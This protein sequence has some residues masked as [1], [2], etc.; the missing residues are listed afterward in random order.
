MPISAEKIP[1]ASLLSLEPAEFVD[2][3]YR[4]ILGREADSPHRENYRNLLRLGALGRWEL[5]ELLCQSPEGRGRGVEFAGLPRRRWSRWCARLPLVRGVIR[6]VRLL[7]HLPG[8]LAEL[9]E[10]QTGGEVE[11]AAQGRRVEA[12]LHQADELQGQ[13]E[14]RQGQIAARQGQAEARLERAEELA[15][16]RQEL[17]EERYRLAGEAGHLVACRLAALETGVDSIRL[18]TRR[19]VSEYRRYLLELAA[20]PRTAAGA[21]PRGEQAPVF[22][23]SLYASFEDEFRGTPEAVRQ[24]VAVY[25]P[26]VRAALLRHPHLPVLDLGC[27]RGEWLELLALEGIPA[28]GVDCNPVVVASLCAQGFAVSH[29]DLFAYLLTLPSAGAAVVTAFHVIEHLAPEQWLTLLDE[30]R[31]VL[32]PGGIAIFETP[33]PRNILVGSGDFYRDPTHRRPVFPDTLQFFGRVRGFENSTAY[34]FSEE[35]AAL[36]PM[37]EYRFDEIGDYLR[38]SRDYAWMGSKES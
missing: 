21:I 10:R 7:R 27:G 2:Q 6:R 3:A 8:L 17:A 28:Q 5:I 37:Q 4:V 34:F 26:W 35:R 25:L 18:E 24:G 30:V 29:S 16:A 11:V 14:A 23:D 12:W 20:P 19:A 22:S 38:V 15:A 33:N 36:L 32:A 31:R 13:V 9:L 1:L